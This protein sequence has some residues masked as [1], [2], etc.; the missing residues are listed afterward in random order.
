M[1]GDSYVFAVRFRSGYAENAGEEYDAP[2]AR[3]QHWSG[4]FFVHW[5]RHTGRW[6]LLHSDLTLEQAVAKVAAGEH[7]RPPI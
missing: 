1:R 4:R 2:F 6:W 7:L 3:I 5:M